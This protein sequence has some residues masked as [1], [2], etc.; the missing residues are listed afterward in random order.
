MK[1]FGFLILSFFFAIRALGQDY[2]DSGFTF[3]HKAEA[4][5][6]MVNGVKEGKWCEYFKR[7]T[8][9][10]PK[11]LSDYGFRLTIYKNG[12][13]VGIQREYGNQC[14]E[15]PYANGKINGIVK[16]Y[17]GTGKIRSETPYTD[18][19]ING[20]E[21]IYYEYSEKLKQETTYTNGIKGVTRNYS[22]NGKEIK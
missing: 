18:G 13:P 19:I 20:V 11:S 2:S 6:Q 22:E 9:Q 17:F 7:D 5:N 12:K 14:K 1:P 16:T 4:K 21:R 15:I 3:K 10:T 8:N